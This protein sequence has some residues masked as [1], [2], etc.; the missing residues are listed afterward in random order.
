MNELDLPALDGANPLGFLAALG[1]LAVLSETDPT[2]KLGWRQRARWAPYLASKQPIDESSIISS[3]VPRLRGRETEASAQAESAKLREEYRIARKKVK[4]ARKALSKQGLRGKGR[5]EAYT[6]DVA[7]LEASAEEIRKSFLQKL[8][9]A[10]PSLELSLGD[11][12]DLD[13]AEFREKAREFLEACEQEPVAIQMLASFATEENR[14]DRC[15]RTE[16][17]FVDSSGQLAFL[18]AIRDLAEK[19]SEEKVRL[20]LFH[21]W[22]RADEKLSL[23]FDPV[24]DRR[25]ALL[26]RDPTANDNKSRSEWMANLLAYHALRLF[27]CA[28]TA[29]G[30]GTAGWNIKTEPRRFTWSIWRVPLGKDTIRSLLGLA[31]LQHEI[32]PVALRL[33]GIAS[34][35]RSLR[36]ENGDYVNFSPS[37]A[38]L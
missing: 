11:K 7:P 4:D 1:T 28:L 23:R 27:P 10:V 8:R 21:P 35:Y 20:C 29:A 34:V 3:L 32:P 13:A 17:D 2:L 26:D 9:T 31:D 18:K 33:C 24:E 38:V 5:T 25:Y 6:R 14:A 22:R 36:I 12:I 37:S 16:F 30:P 15:R 19:V